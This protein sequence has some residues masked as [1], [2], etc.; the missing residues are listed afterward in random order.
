MKEFAKAKVASPHDTE[1]VLAK[2]KMWAIWFLSWLTR[3]KREVLGAKQETEWGGSGTDRG[4]FK[5]E[6]WKASKE[7]FFV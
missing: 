7:D 5:K 6:M 3:R 4:W 1:L 2:L